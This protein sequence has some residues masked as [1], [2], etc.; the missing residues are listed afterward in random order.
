LDQKFKIRLLVIGKIPSLDLTE[1]EYNEILSSSKILY[2]ALDFEKKYE[3]TVL[4]WLDI[5]SELYKI[6][7]KINYLGNGSYDDFIE[8]E[9]SLNRRIL[10]FLS[11]SE[12]YVDTACSHIHKI[13]GKSKNLIKQET[14]SNAYEND[15][16][17]R[18]VEKFRNHIK[19]NSFA[20][21]KTSFSTQRS[22]TDDSI[23]LRSTH[24]YT[25][26]SVLHIDKK[27]RPVIEGM[28]DDI[29]LNEILKHYLSVINNIHLVLS[30]EINDAVDMARACFEMWLAKYK[31]LLDTDSN[32]VCAFNYIADGD[33][34]RNISGE[35]HLSL[36]REKHRQALCKRNRKFTLKSNYQTLIPA[37]KI[38]TLLSK[39]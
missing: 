39:T 26:K 29:D 11:V 33:I 35:I 31:L 20:I 37:E 27:M 7:N 21:S 6:S 10:N 38:K 9:D 23:F 15:K 25:K 12:L 22:F 28:N 24:L 3:Y 18:F 4:N 16:Y 19:H 34:E 2:N 5:E 13:T 8:V 1:V 36:E 32:G 30:E 17:Y 14:F